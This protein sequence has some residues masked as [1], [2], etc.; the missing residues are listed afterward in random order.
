M[1]A[2]GFWNQDGFFPALLSPLSAVYARIGEQRMARPGWRAPVPVIC[3]GNA[4]VGG[5]GK[6]PVALD[7]AARLMARGETP[8]FLTRGYRGSTKGVTRVDPTRHDA[9]TVGDEALLLAASASTWVGADRIATAR[10]AIAQGAT[11]LVMDDGLQNPGLAKTLAFMVI[12]ASIGFGNGRV[13]PAGP[14]REKV[15]ACAG[16]VQAAIIIGDDSTGAHSALPGTLPVLHATIVPG[17]QLASL[18]GKSVIA[19]AGIGQPEK[20][21]AM[22]RRAGLELVAEHSFPDHHAFSR[23]DLLMLSQ[24]NTICVCTYKDYVRIPAESRGRFAPIGM[25]LAWQNADALDRFLD[26]ALQ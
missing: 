3:V 23:T 8:H 2:P 24:G 25:S 10:A 13:L 26:Q 15:D 20:F 7:I 22:L 19:F 1:R 14:L 4:T 17:P 9:A 6:T 11:V 18:H 16:R 21:F 5:T 12:D